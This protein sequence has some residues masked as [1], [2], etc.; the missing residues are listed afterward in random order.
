LDDGVNDQQVI[1]LINNLTTLKHTAS[2][3]E[4]DNGIDFTPSNGAAVTLLNDGGV[5]K[6]INR[7]IY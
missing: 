5:W 2:T 4:L 6:E 3:L 1:L 7:A